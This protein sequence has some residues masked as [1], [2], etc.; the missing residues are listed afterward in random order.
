MPCLALLL[1]V[2]VAS[3]AP[4]AAG[5]DPSATRVRASGSTTAR[6][7]DDRFSD[8][9]NVKDYGAK[10]DGAADD[11]AAIQ[12]AIDAAGSGATIFF[13]PGTYLL[14]SKHPMNVGGNILL[15]GKSNIT[16]TG[17]GAASIIK[18]GDGDYAGSA[19]NVFSNYDNANPSRFGTYSNIA[20]REL[21]FDLNGARNTYNYRSGPRVVIQFGDTS[22]A[23]VENCVFSHMNVSN[24]IAIGR[25]HRSARGFRVT[26]CRF[27]DPTDGDSGNIDHS[28][29]Y[30]M[31]PGAT[32][33]GNQ[34]INTTT[35]GRVVS[36]ATEL[37][38]GDANFSENTITGYRQAVFAVSE[39]SEQ[40]QPVYGQIIA[41]NTASDLNAY[42]VTMWGRT[43]G[44]TLKGVNVIGNTVALAPTTTGQDRTAAVINTTS[45]GDF[46]SVTIANNVFTAGGSL[47]SGGRGV[48]I[49]GNVQDWTIS[50]NTFSGFSMGIWQGTVGAVDRFV[51]RMSIIDNRFVECGSGDEIILIDVGAGRAGAVNGLTVKGNTFWNGVAQSRP[52]VVSSHRQ[53]N[54]LISRNLAANFTPGARMVTFLNAAPANYIWEGIPRVSGNR[55]DASVTLTVGVDD[56][57]QTFATALEANRTVNLSM[58]GAGNGA[59]FRIVRTGLGP[60]TL[61]VGGLKTIPRETAA[62]VDVMFNGTAWVLTGYGTL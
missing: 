51:T 59:K 40:R 30:A 32:I 55:G 34:F 10:G 48:Q 31:I 2:T 53:A 13:P 61:N 43:A 54:Y 58:G 20:F 6:T 60:G 9:L 49:F 47:Y 50:G 1:A 33:Q 16:F 26:G 42:F 28:T 39:A 22:N 17:A 45:V 11:R 62:F 5:P 57:V 3:A 27:L 41:N 14:K 8:Q 38:A 25:P 19:F 46:Q 18:L 37:H 35:R 21:A 36:T 4:P 29:I 44:D 7:L 24:T 12:G 15:I 56:E 52:I 23:V